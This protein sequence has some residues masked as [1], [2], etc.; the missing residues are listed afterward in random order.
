MFKKFRLL[1]IFLAFICLVGCGRDGRAIQI[2]GSDTMVNLGQ[3]W[4]EEFMKKYPEIA[5]AVTGGGSGTGIAALINGTTDIAMCSRAMK[6]KEI[7]IAREKGVDPHEIRVA[8]DGIAIVVAPLNP[9]NRLTV[10]QLSD[11]F[12]RKI[13]NWKEVG[14]PEKK[15]IAL[16]RDRNS[17]T[18][19]FF[20]EQ[21]VKLGRKKSP[22]EFAKNV[23]MMPSNQAIVEEVSGNPE[24]IGYIGLGYLNQRLKAIAVAKGKGSRYSLPS[25]RAV[26]DRSYPISRSLYMYSN[27]APAGDLLKLADFILSA[28]GQKIV[29]EM[30]FVPLAK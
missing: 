22:K 10:T 15:I 28:K 17:G 19:I 21:V 23:L 11:I 6:P 25:V 16:S 1:A 3:A 5:V 13:E 27:G 12:T 24:A 29:L 7:E 26:A 20:L 4:A 9:L 18:H 2:K 30:D 14:G 8:S